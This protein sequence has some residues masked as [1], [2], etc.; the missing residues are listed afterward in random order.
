MAS[1]PVKRLYPMQ[2]LGRAAKRC[3]A[4][5]PEARE[6]TGTVRKKSEQLQP[7]IADLN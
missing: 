6:Q 3:G 7:L 2:L 1:R 5:P 4:L